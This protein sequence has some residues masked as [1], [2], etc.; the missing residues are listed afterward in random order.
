MNI[1]STSPASAS[2]PS[3]AA[4]AA[5]TARKADA[6]ASGQDSRTEDA[7]VDGLESLDK[8]LD[9]GNLDQ[10]RKS[11]VSVRKAAS[12]AGDGTPGEGDPLTPVA[13]ALKKGDLAAARSAWG[14][15]RNAIED[16]DASDFPVTITGYSTFSITA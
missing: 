3:P 13:S 4:P 12:L 16:E 2:W 9:K 15:F 5:R 8:A 1:T 7:I 6:T 11:L 10:A 14:E